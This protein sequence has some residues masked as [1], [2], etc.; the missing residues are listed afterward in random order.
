MYCFNC[1][2]QLPDESKFCSC[3]GTRICDNSKFDN[4]S[5]NV[6]NNTPMSDDDVK[7]SGDFSETSKNFLVL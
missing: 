5:E 4:E 7:I 1:G 3:C 6:I 2:Q